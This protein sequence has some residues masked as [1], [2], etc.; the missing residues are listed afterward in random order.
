ML[1]VLP[2][3]M[4]EIAFVLGM[5]LAFSAL[6]I[7]FRDLQYILP[8]LFTAWLYVTPVLYPENL[9]PESVSIAG[10]TVPARSLLSG[11]PMLYF[12]NSYRDAMYHQRWPSSKGWL[13]MFLIGSV[14]LLLGSVVFARLQRR[15]AEEL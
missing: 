14:S 15:F 7:F 2:I 9:I 3:M 12:V 4:L 10:A 6:N 13:A 8:V 11:N 5:A 1:A